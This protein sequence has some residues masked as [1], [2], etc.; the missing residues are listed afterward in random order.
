MKTEKNTLINICEIYPYQFNTLGLPEYKEEVKSKLLSL[1]NFFTENNILIN[2]LAIK[3]VGNDKYFGDRKK[4]VED[5]FK[6]NKNIKVYE[7][8]DIEKEF[9]P[10]FLTEYNNILKTSKDGRKLK[11]QDITGLVD[12]I[13]YRYLISRDE[14]HLKDF[15]I[16]LTKD[17]E[18]FKNII[19]NLVENKHQEYHPTDPECI[20]NAK[21]TEKIKNIKNNLELIASNNETVLIYGETGTGKECV[22]NSIHFLKSLNSKKSN[23][24]I[25]INCAAIPENLFESLLFGYTKGAFT[26]ATEN[27]DGWVKEAEGGTLFLDE[28]DKM[29]LYLQ[30]KLLRFIQ[31]KKYYPLGSAKEEKIEDI[32]IISATN[33]LPQ[34]AVTEKKLLKDLYHRIS[35]FIIKTPPL[36][37][38]EK[39][40]KIRLIGSFINRYVHSYNSNKKEYKDKIKF[41]ITSIKKNDLDKL[42]SYDWSDGNARELAKVIT[43][44]IIFKE[45]QTDSTYWT[46]KEIPSPV[47]NNNFC[48]DLSN[49]KNILTINEITKEY[50]RRV[51]NTISG[52]NKTKTA[53]ILNISLGSVNKYLK[54]EE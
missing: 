3:N 19:N 32:K 20:L 14:K 23:K 22:V 24:L 41:N 10:N 54:E 11:V 28:I 29:P 12:N 17:K 6:I 52:E 1:N 13:G 2:Y 5:Y 31:S 15:I 26:G 51:Y 40:D 45:I 44:Y 8:S 36:R 30:G 7:N 38:W 27:K 47:N 53:K 46:K 9:A 35:T 39:E 16:K 21:K 33:I 4:I 48:I 34:K 43:R 50:T 49:D 25:P 37:E 42:L 18:Y